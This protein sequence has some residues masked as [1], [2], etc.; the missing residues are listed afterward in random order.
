MRSSILRGQIG[1][2]LRHV[3]W[4]LGDRRRW[5]LAVPVLGFVGAASELVL[6]V[7]IVQALLALV[8]GV[9]RVAASV[10]G[11]ALEGSPL[12]VLALGAVAGVTSIVARVSEGVVVGRLAA[13]AA[14]TARERVIRSY[15]GIGYAEVLRERDG[16]LQQLLGTNVTHASQSV[17]VLGTVL[18]S[19]TNLAIYATFVAL[20]SPFVAV[21]FAA[22]GG[23]LFTAFRGLRRRSKRISRESQAQVRDIQLQATSL[24][25]LSRELQLFDVVDEARD[26]LL[27]LNRRAR[28]T[29]GRLRT[30]QRIVPTLFQQV[31]MLAVVGVVAL[32]IQVDLDAAAFGT[33][34]ILAV[35]SLSFLQQ[36]NTSI[37][38][39]I[40]MGPYLDE[41]R[42]AVESQ[43]RL[44]R[45]RGDAHLDE[46]S[47]LEL[48]GVSFGYG[49]ELVLRDVDLR[50][51]RGEWIGIV[52]PSG[53]GK[54]TLS[55]VLAGLL[56]PDAGSYR[57]NDVDAGAYDAGSW[58]ARFAVLSQE[59]VLV[60]GTIRENVEFFRAP[61]R[62]AAER[63]AEAAAI[64]S[65]IDDLPRGWD[66]E[67]GD[68]NANLSGGQR[69]RVALARALFGQPQV[70]ILDEPT[71]ALDAENTRIIEESLGSLGGDAI[72][73][74]V[75]HGRA[76]LDR[77]DRFV[78]VDGGRI[79]AEGGADDVGL[80]AYT[81][82]SDR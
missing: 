72:V 8:D 1:D 46:V 64:R 41:L 11:V 59:P 62:D 71:S 66:T 78:V 42:D 21:V 69:Q 19:S 10:A 80:D 57:V 76:L 22:L 77:C 32:A 3:A 34:A 33:A 81:G 74:V 48:S 30:I 12:Q 47:E 60:R 17:P 55:N 15:F 20:S 54:T 27:G 24:S 13:R 35:R 23:L 82:P 45:R 73:V 63:A 75:S 37:Q 67:V 4:L 51:A 44:Q 52:G 25:R 53:G 31:V 26:E 5:V 9:D 18:A 61:D 40:E 14:G 2:L 70:L 79:V 36:L 56:V 38:Q 6:L 7:S 65:V 16:R 68:G 50:I 39:S 49:D 43:R 28:L 58:A 29:L